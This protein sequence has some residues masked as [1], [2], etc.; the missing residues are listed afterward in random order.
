MI[1][2][3]TKNPKQNSNI[4]LQTTNPRPIA[5]IVTENENGLINIAPYSLFAPLSFDPPTV[6]VSFRAKE[7]GNQKD[8]LN[9]IYQNKKCTICM[10]KPNDKELMHQTAEDLSSSI[11]EAL[12]FDIKTKEIVEGYPPI[13]SSSP[14]AYFCDFDQEIEL[15]SSSAIPL[16]L[17]IKEIFVDDTLIQDRENM[18]IEFNGVGHIVGN[19]YKS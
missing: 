15:E 2:N 6:V 13:I 10:V 1:I 8:T 3:S 17:N 11:S 18:T 4:I 19:R 16:I 12:E 5:W 7:D 14:I 9:N